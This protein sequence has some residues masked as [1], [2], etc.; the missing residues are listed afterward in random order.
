MEYPTKFRMKVLAAR[1]EKLISP[2]EAACL[3][4]RQYTQ[5]LL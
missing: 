3:L 1:K 2:E 5:I 4:P